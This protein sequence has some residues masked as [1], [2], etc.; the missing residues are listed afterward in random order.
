MRLKKHKFKERKKKNKVHP[1]RS[2]QGEERG[3]TE[4]NSY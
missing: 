4:K 1:G 2:I 3:N